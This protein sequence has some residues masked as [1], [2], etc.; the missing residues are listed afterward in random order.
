MRTMKLLVL[1]AFVSVGLLQAQD[2]TLYVN[3]ERIFEEFYKTVNANIAFEDQKKDF[4]AR[5]S[6]IRDEL[7]NLDTQAQQL[8]EE[9]RNDLLPREARETSQR[10]L[11]AI[12][13]RLREKNRELEQSRQE[14]LQNLQ[15]IRTKREEDLVKDI[16]TVIDKYADEQGATHVIEVSG[17]TFNRVQVY[18]RYPKEKDVTEIILKL[19]NQGHEDELKAAKEKL[20]SIRKA[21]NERLESEAGKLR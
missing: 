8:D 18:L 21:A 1:F 13:Q 14:G 7:R 10:K 16:L 5:L 2:K 20:D 9:S 15:R 17:K 3:L 11:Q 4:E 19:V 6:L 12:I